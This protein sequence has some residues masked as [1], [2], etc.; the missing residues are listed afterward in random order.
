MHEYIYRVNSV[1]L[2][3]FVGMHGGIEL[4]S[5]SDIRRD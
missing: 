1:V 2:L 5:C 4:Y 3:H